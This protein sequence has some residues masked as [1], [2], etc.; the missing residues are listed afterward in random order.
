MIRKLTV[1]TITIILGYLF[2]LYETENKSCLKIDNKTG[3]VF[4]V[5]NAITVS[6][7]KKGLMGVK[8]LPNNH[9]MLFH[10][11]PPTKQLSFWMK[12]TLIPLDILFIDANNMIYKIA[13][14]NIPKSLTKI[15]PEQKARYVLE[16]NAGLADKYHIEVG[17]KIK[18]CK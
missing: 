17:D 9:G 5:D 6:Q 16:I 15:S 14:D 2:I 13:K 8:S 4:Y 10:F 11:N 12:N 18:F 7:I 1:L 3:S